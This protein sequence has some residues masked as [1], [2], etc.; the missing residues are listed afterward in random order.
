MN[1]VDLPQFD[2]LS[3]EE[4]SKIRYS[5]RD[6]GEDNLDDSEVFK[7]INMASKTPSVCNRQSWKVRYIKCPEKVKD[8]LIIQNGLT[9]NGEN[10][11]KLLVV[12][13]DKQYMNG[14]HE[15]NQ[16]Y[17]D[18]GLFMMSLLYA[19]TSIGIASCTLNT[20]F[21]MK[22]ESNMRQLL[23]V[24]DSEDFIALIAIGTYPKTF[25]VAKSPRDDYTLF[26]TVIE[27]K[28]AG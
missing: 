7:A 13:A 27:P 28:E 19:L 5:L 14:G 16:T 4:L 2:Q 15:R 23:D 21:D 18:G 9:G 12:T 22:R 10:L 8:T 17:I 11:R 6:F 25:K 26:T 24:K 1:S 3:F 20:N